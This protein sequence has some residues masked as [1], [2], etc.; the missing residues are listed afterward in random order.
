MPS[1]AEDV[2]GKDVLVVFCGFPV[3]KQG[4]MEAACERT[5]GLSSSQRNCAS[6]STKG[7]SRLHRAPTPNQQPLLSV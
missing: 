2:S 3:V 1:L 7:H 5:I 4:E 6:E